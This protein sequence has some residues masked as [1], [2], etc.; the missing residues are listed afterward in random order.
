MNKLLIYTLMT[1][2]G[3]FVC[4]SI[5]YW[6]FKTGFTSAF[7]GSI[8]AALGGVGGLIITEYFEKHKKK[9]IN[10]TSNFC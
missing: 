7:G 2:V 3:L 5:M 4:F 1:T 6:I 9:K 8:S 10:N